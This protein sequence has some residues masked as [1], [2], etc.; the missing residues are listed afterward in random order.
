MSPELYRI[1]TRQRLARRQALGEARRIRG[2][3][4][5]SDPRGLS[6]EVDSLLRLFRAVR[7]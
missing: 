6:T 4:A 1:L 2:Q 3:M 7:P 5:S